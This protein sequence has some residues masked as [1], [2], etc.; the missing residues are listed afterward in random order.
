MSG[1]AWFDG[2]PRPPAASRWRCS[3][4][5]ATDIAWLDCSALDLPTDP[6]DFFCESAG[7]ILT[8]GSHCGD[9][10]E[11]FVLL[12]FATP[13]FTLTDGAAAPAH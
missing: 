7:V 6:A 12:V 9:G 11:G 4:P 2:R 8:A 1:G 10:F 5:E 13:A 3:L